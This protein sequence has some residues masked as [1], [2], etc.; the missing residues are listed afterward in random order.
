MC[1]KPITLSAIVSNYTFQSSPGMTLGWI[2]QAFMAS[3]LHKA[4]AFMGRNI[5]KKLHLPSN[6]VEFQV[7][8]SAFEEI[9]FLVWRK[10]KACLLMLKKSYGNMCNILP[11][12]CTWDKHFAT[13][14]YILIGPLLPC[15][16]PSTTCQTCHLIKANHSFPHSREMNSGF[17]KSREC[18]K[19]VSNC[20]SRKPRGC[21]L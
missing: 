4:F 19:W 15:H 2:F 20:K 10:I 11:V 13:L 17:S 3:L 7:G 9:F 18:T 21:A 14:N 8:L 12:N 16:I 5:I 1:V 6:S